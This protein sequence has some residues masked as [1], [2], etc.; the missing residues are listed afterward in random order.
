[1]EVI[2]TMENRLF[3]MMGSEVVSGFTCKANKT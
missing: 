2:N 3:N 1:M